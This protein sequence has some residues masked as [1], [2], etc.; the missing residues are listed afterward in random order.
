MPKKN[1]L[2]IYLI[3]DE[4]ANDD[5]KILKGTKKVLGE[6]EGVG[7]A[8]FVPSYINVPKWLKD[9][10][11]DKLSSEEIFASNARVVLITRVKVE[12]EIEKTFAI[13]M[14]YG[15][16]LLENET[17][18]NDFGLKV[19]LN[20]ISHDNLRKIIKR[21]IGGNQKTSSEQLPLASDIDEFG[22]DVENDLISAVTGLSRDHNIAKGM[23]SGSDLLSLNVEVDI[24]NLT[25]FLKEV[26]KKYC[27]VEYRK[28]FGW[29]DHIKKVKDARLISRLEQRVVELINEN[30]PNIWMAV[31]DV[32]EWENIKGF[33][34][35]KDD[36]EDDIEIVKVINSFQN[37]FSDF[38]Q[39]KNKNITAISNT[40]GETTYA[41]WKASKC[42]VGELEVDG[43]TYCINNGSWY[44]VDTDFVRSVNAEYETIPIS[45]MMFMECKAGNVS[46]NEYTTEFV[47]SQSDY[48]ICMD[49]K[50]IYHGGGR[51]QVEL[52]D[53]LTNDGKY[54]HIKPYSGSAT[55]SHLFNQSVVSA[56]LVITDK[57]FM[58]KANEKIHEV[59]DKD[60]FFIHDGQ[61]P[62]V[63]LA[64]IS[65]EDVDRPNIPFFSKVALRHTWQ[66]LKA[67]NCSLEIKNIRKKKD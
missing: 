63:I 33:R 28:N 41:V 8:Y 10:Y 51:S 39:L 46:E 47:N 56:E 67:Y 23:M 65:K 50:T 44:C 30:A 6:L 3:K 19:V 52:C 54:I 13:T 26:Y 25:H 59:T 60:E 15:K 32:L 2:S 37:D 64:I 53:I 27:S 16:H 48:M 49:K 24:S 35:T 9:F 22:F 20:S 58:K 66:R 4:Y 61:H 17:V 31:P 34:Y 62:D 57:V 43:K 1:K 29:I 7:T 45:N 42:L 12:D 5:D 11:C 14:G 40:D 21:N 38:K 18:E 36:L 55:L